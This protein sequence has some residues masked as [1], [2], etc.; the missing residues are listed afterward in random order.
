MFYVSSI[1]GIA[2]CGKINP[3]TTRRNMQEISQIDHLVAAAEAGTVWE[4]QMS[5]WKAVRTY[6]TAI[7]CSMILSLCLI[8]EGYDTSLTNN[9]FALPQ[10]R[11]KFG[12]RLDNGDYQLTASWMSGLQNGT[13]ISQMLGLMFAGL[14]AERYGYKKT[15]IGALVLLTCFILVFF[16]ATNIVMLLV[17]GLLCGV[18]WGAF[19]TLTT[20][21]A[22][23]VTPM[24]LRPILTTFV[25][26]CW[27][28]GQLISAGVLRHLL[29][30]TDDW[31]WRIPYAIQWAFP[32]LLILGVL[33]IPESPIWLV[34][35]GR[36]DDA[37]KTLRR[38]TS[39]TASEEDITNYLA[40]IEYT[41]LLEKHIQEG[42]SYLDCF[43]GSNLRRTEIACAVW[44]AQV[45][46]GIWFGGNVAY[47]LQ[48]AGFDP[49]QSLNFGIGL[50][51]LALAGTLGA[52]FIVSRVG[53][54]TLYL[55][56]LGTMLTVLLIIGFMGIPTPMEAIG[57]ASGALMM[58]FVIAYDLTV[59][60]VCYCLVSEIPST[61]LRI[62]TVVLARNA[63]NIASIV[64]N[65]LNPPILN[66]TAWNLRGKGGFIWSTLCLTMM[67]WTYFRLPETKGLSLSEID[68][69]FEQQVSARKF[70]DTKINAFQRELVTT[71]S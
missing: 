6:P 12:Q 62:N 45:F 37:R 13:Q 2:T 58:V 36:L 41:D 69:L 11:E 67:I 30:R 40:F 22:A 51:G 60:P 55:V 27:V 52:W 8:M 9:F 42:T 64:A 63:Y 17:G 61:R 19:Q 21:Y 4:K 1:F 57:W 66:P 24:C 65:F 70:H 20:T 5:I 68:V 71:E 56:G 3:E 26:M 15:I 50:N 35:K 54:R 43:K 44:V 59:G 23:D 29:G 25:N 18:P 46:C 7:G 34:R 32:P 16:F 49:A 14:I 31:A 33:F 47:F 48:Q 28:V 39:K 53:R 10:F 38:L